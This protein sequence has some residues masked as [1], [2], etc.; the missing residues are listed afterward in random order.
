MDEKQ[1]QRIEAA[2][3]RIQ[4]NLR[5]IVWAIAWIT[6]FGLP[7]V[8]WFQ[9]SDAQTELSACEADGMKHAVRESG[10]FAVKCM[11][12]RGFD[13]AVPSPACVA[14]PQPE[15]FARRGLWRTISRAAKT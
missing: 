5:E 2:L 14:L 10:A 8:S 1:V 11:G 4:A 6:I 13:F 9:E 15:C 3:G 12:G 7:V